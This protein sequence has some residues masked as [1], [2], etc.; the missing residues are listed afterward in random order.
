MPAE[1]NC[2]SNICP[3]IPLNRKFDDV[4]WAVVAN[5]DT[6]ILNKH[7]IIMLE[8]I[9]ENTKKM[10]EIISSLQAHAGKCV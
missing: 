10:S 2:A 8:L 1:L 7:Q 6:D 3:S 4:I 9:D 5:R